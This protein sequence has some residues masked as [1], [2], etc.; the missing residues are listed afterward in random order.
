MDNDKNRF[1]FTL[2]F[3]LSSFLAYRM[4]FLRPRSEPW[5]AL[6]SSTDQPSLFCKS[7]IFEW[8]MSLDS[9]GT[10]DQSVQPRMLTP[11]PG[12]SYRF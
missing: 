4:Y 10:F 2:L 3:C 7:L 5:V 12:T 1:L 9:S 6:W 11:V 8:T